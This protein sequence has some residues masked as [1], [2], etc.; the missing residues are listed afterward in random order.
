M[1]EGEWSMIRIGRKD[2]LWEKKEEFIT[3]EIYRQHIIESFK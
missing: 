2:H 1:K 3:F